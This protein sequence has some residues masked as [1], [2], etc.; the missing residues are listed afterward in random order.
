[1]ANVKTEAFGPPRRWVYGATL[2]GF[3]AAWVLAIYSN[4]QKN[5]DDK[6]SATKVVTEVHK[7]M[8]FSI[9]LRVIIFECHI[10]S[11]WTCLMA[12]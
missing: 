2:G 8:T 12:I 11:K 7:W 3:I 1:L 6:S 10:P 9:L 5:P 4:H